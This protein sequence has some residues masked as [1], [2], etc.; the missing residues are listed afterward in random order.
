MS[1][2]ITP[3]WTLPA[4]LASSGVIK[5]AINTLLSLTLFPFITYTS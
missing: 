1:F 4:G 3:P 2:M 5:C